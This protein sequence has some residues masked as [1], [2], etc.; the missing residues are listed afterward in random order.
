MS[1]PINSPNAPTLAASTIPEPNFNAIARSPKTV[2][3]TRNLILICRLC[4]AAGSLG[5]ANERVIAKIQ[6]L[7]ESVMA[8]LMRSIERVSENWTAWADVQVMESLPKGAEE[9]DDRIEERDASV[10]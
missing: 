3:G 2:E 6:S 4:V 5:S 10:G 7:D 8:E 1:Y 9:D